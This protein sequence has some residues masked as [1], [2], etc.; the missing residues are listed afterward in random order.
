MIFCSSCGVSRHKAPARE[1][2]AVLPPDEPLTPSGP[3][4]EGTAGR[5]ALRWVGATLGATFLAFIAQ[6][7]ISA[8]VT[9]TIYRTLGPFAY[10]M[11]NIILVT[12]LYGGAV[13]LS[14]G[15]VLKRSLDGRG[16]RWLE[17]TLA[18]T[19][20]GAL[21][22]LLQPE[23]VWQDRSLQTMLLWG[24][25][26]GIVGGAAK[27]VFQWLALRR[28]GRIRALIFWLPLSA[29]VQTLAGVAGAAIFYFGFQ[30]AMAFQ[31]NLITGLIRTTA[32]AL[33]VALP[34]GAFL[35]SCLR[36]EFGVPGDTHDE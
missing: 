16:T 7:V 6:T 12:F 20:I 26:P 21:V 30:G 33:L 11:I 3:R 27:G 28:L 32:G 10:R 31:A 29:V 13:G 24:A 2:R 36:R 1:P 18:G 15:S 34:T 22:G 9:S 25:F 19:F 17:A 4:F 35:G 14:Q 23:R 8:A 5:F